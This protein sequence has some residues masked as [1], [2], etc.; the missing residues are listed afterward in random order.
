MKPESSGV[1]PQ[2]DPDQPTR[3]GSEH[4]ENA[5]TARF[6][7]GNLTVLAHL[8]RG[9]LARANVWRQKMDMTTHWAVITVTALVS[10][11]FSNPNSEHMILPFCS[12]LVFLLCIVEAR[13]YRFF[14]VWR[15]RVRMLEV[16]LMVPALYNDK[17]LIEGDW[18]EVL[19]NDLLMPT[20][21]MGAWEAVGRRLARTYG[22]L[23]LIIYAAWIFKVYQYAG[24]SQSKSFRDAFAVGEHLPGELVFGIVTLGHLIPLAIMIG[25][26][27]SREASGEIRRKDPTR[28]R[29]PI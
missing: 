17:N 5:L 11:A 16:H 28:R 9:E 15:T 25:T 29:W 27:R 12:C 13:R 14:D 18:R 24:A 6:P 20:Y 21:K 23:F 8:Y 22:Y 4:Q 3:V 26:R 2:S 7:A 1:P 10:I 19:C